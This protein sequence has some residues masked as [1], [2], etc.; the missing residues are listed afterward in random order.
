[1]AELLKSWKMWEDYPCWCSYN[2]KRNLTFYSYYPR[3]SLLEVI[4][5]TRSVCYRVFAVRHDAKS[6]Q[7][8]QK[9]LPA[10]KTPAVS[11]LSRCLC[12]EQLLDHAEQR[13][14]VLSTVNSKSHQ[15]WSGNSCSAGTSK[16]TSHCCNFVLWVKNATMQNVCCHNVK[17]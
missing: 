8:T 12:A 16:S 5:R 6:L 13:M 4:R 15:Q 9:R 1:M 14:L 7:M 10:P 17:N 3:S 11:S 2:I